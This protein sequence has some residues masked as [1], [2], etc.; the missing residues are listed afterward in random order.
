MPV[1]CHERAVHY[2]GG[3][4]C[5]LAH[6]FLIWQ[7]V[8]HRLKDLSHSLYNRPRQLLPVSLQSDGFAKQF[9]AYA[10]PSS[11]RSLQLVLLHIAQC[12]CKHLSDV[13]RTGSSEASCHCLHHNILQ[14]W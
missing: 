13:R 4:S 3:L 9:R 2:A 12:G 11:S 7:W 14:C 6:H 5:L 8:C 10:E 1:R